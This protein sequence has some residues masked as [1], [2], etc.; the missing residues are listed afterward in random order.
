MEEE[1]KA[2]LLAIN[3]HHTLTWVEG[4]RY[5]TNINPEGGYQKLG[6]GGGELCPK[7]IDHIVCGGGGETL[8]ARLLL[9]KEILFGLQACVNVLDCSGKKG[10]GGVAPEHSNCSHN[11]SS[12]EESKPETK[13]T[14][15]ETT[16]T[17]A[18]ETDP[19]E[20]LKIVARWGKL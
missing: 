16:E 5:N 9:P 8:V 20:A 19:T 17:A 7:R 15:V 18:W 14:T 12:H 2:A 1:T 4:V 13:E 6:F 11:T 3:P 10:G